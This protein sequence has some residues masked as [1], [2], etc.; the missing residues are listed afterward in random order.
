RHVH[1][2]HQQRANRRHLLAWQDRGA[3]L[4][5]CDHQAMGVH[6]NRRRSDCW[7]RSVAAAIRQAPP[8]RHRRLMD[9]MRDIVAVLR[10]FEDSTLSAAE[11][12][13]RYMPLWRSLVNEQ[14]AAIAANPAVAAALDELR[15]RLSEGT[16]SAPEYAVAVQQQYA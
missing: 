15:H 10:A 8:A 4:R 16:I 2:E 6:D 1:Q 12:V 3:A 11:L 9:G 14:D 13:E 7:L 5:E